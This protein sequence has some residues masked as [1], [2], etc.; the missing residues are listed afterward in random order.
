MTDAAPPLE[1]IRSKFGLDATHEASTPPPLPDLLNE[2]ERTL[3]RYVVMS[4]DAHAIVTVWVAHVF[5]FQA[6]EFTPYLA[7]TSAT[8]RSG[9][10]RLLEVLEVILGPTKAVSTANISPASLFRLIDDKP[11]MAVLFDE[12]DRFP[13]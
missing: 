12:V 8:K 7:I 1:A 10:S 13:K 6:F 11:G 4:D 5:A 2:I 9:K 3:R